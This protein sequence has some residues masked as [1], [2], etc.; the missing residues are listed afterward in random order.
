MLI[1]LSNVQCND[2][3]C[4]PQLS[5]LIC[6]SNVRCWPQLSMLISLSNVQ[7]NDIDCWPQLS[8]LISLSNV[9][10]NDVDCWPQLSMLISLSH[11]NVMML[12]VDHWVP[13][14]W[15]GERNGGC[16]TLVWW[17]SPRAWPLQ[18]HQQ[19]H[20]R[21]PRTL[22]LRQ[23]QGT[24]GFLCQWQDNT[25]ATFTSVRHIPKSR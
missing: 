4:W 18:T 6:L 1:S 25:I 17:H 16:V 8:M 11:S 19:L 10:W 20:T 7:C 12:I 23:G 9:Q 13:D 14:T 24:R 2:V 22:R 15:C 5:M 21:H 3:D